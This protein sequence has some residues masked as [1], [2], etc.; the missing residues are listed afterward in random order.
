MA[1][2]AICRKD[3]RE[4]AVV[5]IPGKLERSTTKVLNASLRWEIDIVAISSRLVIALCNLFSIVEALSPELTIACGSLACLLSPMREHGSQLS[6]ARH[7]N[8][9]AV[10]VVLSAE[11]G[12]L[13]H[14]LQE[15][16]IGVD[17]ISLWE[18]GIPLRFR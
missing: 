13:S 4:E 1:I 15:V 12:E 7:L 3:L 5:V 18:G 6:F 10:N 16:I 8:S 17:C 9:V 14:S 2:V 11:G